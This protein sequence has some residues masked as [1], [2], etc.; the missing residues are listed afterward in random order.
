VEITSMSPPSSGGVAIG[1]LLGVLERLEAREPGGQPP[2]HS[3]R[4]LHLWTEAARRAFADRNALLGDPDF[5]DVPVAQ[6]VSAEYLQARASSVDRLRA[7]R[8]ADVGPGLPAPALRAAPREGTHTT[9][10][11]VV[12]ARGNAVGV[13][14]TINSLYGS[15]VLV[16]GAGFFL[17]DEMDDFTT[18]PGAPNQFGLVQGEA[19]AIAPR[20]RMLSAMSPTV[21]TDAA[22]GR[23]RLVV[24][25]PGGPTIITTVAQV[26]EAHV[27]RGLEPRAAV[28][29]PRLH[30]QH[31]PDVLRYERGGLRPA[32]VE[33][34][35]ALG[36]AV[37]ERDGAQ[38][39]QGDVQAIFVGADGVAL[40]VS[41]PRRGGAPVAVVERVGAVH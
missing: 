4:H 10:Y 39:L 1:A 2:L 37:Q 7:S 11:S 29:A 19:N 21:V 23:V 33:A 30:H 38:P 3:A 13:T 14:T 34:L 20:K 18:T 15:G 41:D 32:T 17:N 26:I 24:G 36:H 5:A 9:H 12:D 40:G 22:S 25:S 6:L 27:G 28:A 8:S 16:T 35:R 31:L